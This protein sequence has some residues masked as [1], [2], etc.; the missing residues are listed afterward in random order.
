MRVRT[1]RRKATP[2]TRFGPLFSMTHSAPCAIGRIGHFGPAR[3]CRRERI[4]PAPGSPRSPA[5]A[6]PRIAREF[7]PAFRKAE[8]NR[9]RPPSRRARSSRRSD[10]GRSIAGSRRG[11]LRIASGVSIFSTIGLRRQVP[12]GAPPDGPA[13]VRCP[14]CVVRTKSR[15]DRR[16]RRRNP[17][18]ESPCASAAAVRFPCV[19]K[20]RPLSALSRTPFSRAA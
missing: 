20:L 7:P 18:P 15:R 6:P 10:Y 13:G 9:S 8:R 17:D 4:G 11:K 14:Q 5:C 3:R 2:S 12:A 19:G 1:S 16:E